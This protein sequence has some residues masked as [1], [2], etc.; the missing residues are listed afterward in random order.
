MVLSLHPSFWFFQGGIEDKNFQCR[1]NRAIRSVCDDQVGAVRWSFESDSN[2]RGGSKWRGIVGSWGCFQ[3]V[4][5]VSAHLL[6]QEQLVEHV[7][8]YDDMIAPKMS[9]HHQAFSSE[10]ILAVKT[11]DCVTGSSQCAC[12]PE[13]SS[14]WYTVSDWQLHGRF[15]AF[16]WATTTTLCY[17]NYRRI[18]SGSGI[19]HKVNQCH[20]LFPF[21][22]RC[23]ATRLCL[24]TTYDIGDF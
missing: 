7:Q 4:V 1:T 19:I 3:I 22:Q 10:S 17:G 13:Y 11:R 18:S 20:A 21:W 24:N 16:F 23:H 5:C 2:A 14:T 15:Q 8:R 9:N 12:W 6:K